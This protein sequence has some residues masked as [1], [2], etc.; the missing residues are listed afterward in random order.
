MF[1]NRTSYSPPAPPT[2]TVDVFPLVQYTFSHREWG[3]L[4][5]REGERSNRGDKT[6]SWVENINTTECLLEIGYLQSIN[7]DK[8]LPQI[9][10]TGQFC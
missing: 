3:E 9:V 2:H 6:Q 5:Q 10:F 7:S 8:H 4:N 1:S